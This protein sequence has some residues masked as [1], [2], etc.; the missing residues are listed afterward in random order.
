MDQGSE[1]LAPDQLAAQAQDSI[2]GSMLIDDRCVGDVLAA[3]DA[4]D[5]TSGTHKATFLAIKRL[6]TSGRPVDPV[7][8]IDEMQGGPRY[9]QFVRECMDITPTAANV[10]EYCK[11]LRERTRLLRLREIGDQLARCYDKTEAEQLMA[12]A[13]GLMVDRKDA[14]VTSA[15]EAAKDFIER[16]RDPVPPDYFTWGITSLNQKLYV[17][18]GDMV[19]IGGRPSS[20]KTL[21]SVALALHMAKIYRVGYYSLETRTKKLVDRAMA[22]MSQVP[23]SD[24]K[25]RHFSSQDWA[26][27][28]QAAVAYAKLTLDH[29]DAAKMTVADISSRA[30]SLRHQVVFVDY[31]QLISGPGAS[32]YE[33]VSNISRDLHLMAQDLGITVIALAQLSRE[34]KDKQ[35]RLIPPSMSDFRDSGQIEQDADVALLLWPEDPDDYRS[36]RILKI[37]KNKEGTKGKIVLTFDGAR[38]TMREKDPPSAIQDKPV[39]EQLP[40]DTPTPFDQPGG[41]A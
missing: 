8:V 21:L 32:A 30:L 31:L 3:I 18:L 16:M 10:L 11:I 23:L 33:R 26:A 13:N 14:R 28:S 17:E 38:Q 7:T 39:F 5:F 29:V 41:Q 25:E 24:I 27:M 15:A 2:I 9:V 19:L 37:G 36:D 35:G 20:G 1:R 34:T 22:T 6:F 40:I 12:K 4:A